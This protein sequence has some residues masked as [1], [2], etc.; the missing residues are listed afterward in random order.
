[1]VVEPWLDLVAEWSVQG[2]V[3]DS[4]VRVVGL[5][6][7]GAASGVYRGTVTGSPYL[8][9]DAEI[10]TDSSTR[11]RRPGA[12]LAACTRAAERVGPP[13]WTWGTAVPTA[14]TRGSR[15]ARTASAWCRWARSTPGRRWA[16]SRSR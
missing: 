13:C 7:F 5:T 16:G 10:R 15:G 11:G 6:R 8:G 3:S 14:S 9:C 4:E 2:E 1:M 12:G